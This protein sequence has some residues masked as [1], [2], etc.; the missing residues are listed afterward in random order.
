MLDF[1]FGGRRYRNIE[2]QMVIL[3]KRLGIPAILPAS[4]NNPFS[5][6]YPKIEGT[7]MKRRFSLTLYQK[8]TGKNKRFFTEL[9]FEL[10]NKY[11]YT[12]ELYKERIWSKIG[13]AVGMQDIQIGDPPFDN[14]FIIKSNDDYFATEVL[15]SQQSKDCFKMIFNSMD[16]SF[17]LDGTNLNYKQLGLIRTDRDRVF[18]EHLIE[19]G[20]VLSMNI[21]KFAFDR[22][23]TRM[24]EL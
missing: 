12:L 3:G 13:K 7:L 20:L 9:N 2:Q 8:G 5:K 22:D 16:G 15:K 14:S 23:P 11:E 24:E 18:A 17:K 6:Y 21:E 1:L 10:E 4:R 19:T